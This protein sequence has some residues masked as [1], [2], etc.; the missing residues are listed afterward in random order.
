MQQ[1]EGPYQLGAIQDISPEPEQGIYE[2]RVPIHDAHG[3]EV[4]SAYDYTTDEALAIAR[5]F[6]AAPAMYA[7]LCKA[8]RRSP[9]AAEIVR[10]FR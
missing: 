8:A 1:F 4:G 2:F 3:R 10:T 7:Y 5:L 9:A 6:T